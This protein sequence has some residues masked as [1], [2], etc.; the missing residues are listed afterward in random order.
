MNQC[1]TNRPERKITHYSAGGN[2]ENIHVIEV[3]AIVNLL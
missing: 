2:Y 3:A 1:N